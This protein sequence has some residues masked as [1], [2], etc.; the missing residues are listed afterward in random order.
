MRWLHGLNSVLLVI[1]CGRR[2]RCFDG[3]LRHRIW[4]ALLLHRWFA[5]PRGSTA[6][7]GYGAS[8]VYGSAFG[9]GITRCLGCEAGQGNNA[10]CGLAMGASSHGVGTASLIQKGEHPETAAL[11]IVGMILTGVCHTLLCATPA[12]RSLVHALAR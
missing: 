10:P 11:S 3:D 5:G 12:F 4:Y 2:E 1:W 7:R 6:E 9:L 8:G